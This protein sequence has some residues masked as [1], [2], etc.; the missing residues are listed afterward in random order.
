MRIEVELRNYRC[1]PLGKAARLAFGPGFTAIVGQNNAGKSS[2]LRFFWEYRELWKWLAALNSLSN[3]KEF[4]WGGTQGTTDPDEVFSN[5]NSENLQIRFGLKDL[6]VG[7]GR[8]P[9]PEELVIEISRKNHLASLSWVINGHPVD[10]ISWR[11]NHTLVA[12]GGQY[13][14]QPYAEMFQGLADSVYIGPFRNALNAAGA[15]HYDIEIGHDFINSWSRFKSGASKAE[16]RAAIELTEELR[17]IF[18]FQ[19]LEINPTNEGTTM[20]VNVDGQPYRLEE[21]GAGL[22]QFL[23]TLAFVAVKKPPYVFIDEPE[24]NLHPSLQL[25]FLTTLASFARGGV[26]FGTHSLGLARAANGG[27]YSVRRQEPGNSELHEFEATPDL[28]ELLGELSFSGYQDL[29]SSRVLLVEGKHEVLAF[30]RILRLYGKEHEIAIV[31]LAGTNLINADSAAELE[32][33][34]KLST[35]IWVVIDSERKDAGQALAPPR[36]AFVQNCEKLGFQVC[37]LG[38]RAFENYLTE[39]AIKSVKAD[40]TAPL[41]HYETLKEAGSPWAKAENWRIAG[42]LGRSDLDQTDLGRFL[43][44]LTA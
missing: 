12:G 17:R 30:Q 38:R 5:L 2:L 40:S 42:H 11:G 29:G 31:S 39:T 7:G 33:L 6:A 44:R 19:S 16:N 15:R 20:Q 14:I 8:H 43:T 26:V 41:G 23:I 32:E 9:A 36:E 35:D 24:L 4:G 27:L 28:A 22:A 13:A 18:G 25:D 3:A 1:F 10:R 34:R 21:L 37:V